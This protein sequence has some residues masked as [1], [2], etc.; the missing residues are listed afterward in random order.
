MLALAFAAL[1]VASFL[2]VAGLRDV[3]VATGRTQR[4]R[5]LVVDDSLDARAS[6][7]FVWNRRFVRTRPGRWV[8]RQLVLA[9]VERPPLLVA[10]VVA[11]AAVASGWALF[12]VL[13]PVFALLG[14][15][16]G[17]QGLRVFLA[18]AR[19]RRLEA[20]INQMPELARV[21]ANATSAGL[22][23]RTA[24]DMAADELADPASTELRIVAD[25]MRVGADLETAMAQINE[26]L[27]S[28]EIRVLIS[29]LLV[30][31]RSGGSLVTSLRDIAD[32]L[33]MRKEVRREVRTVLAQA[34]L[35]GYLVV[36]LGL[37]L[38]AGLNLFHSGTVQRMTTEP[39]GQAALLTSGVLYAIGL[40][41]IRRITRIEP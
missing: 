16:I 31:S 40:L 10:I 41:M 37:M 18:R 27:P 38:T 28:R 20:F 39:L 25:Q 19:D 8:Q 9:G 2:A 26:R 21:L 34:V 15:V 36:G 30:S 11:A 4:L 5:L 22:S 7:M 17:L 14:A 23:I 32:T 12:V 29:T 3:L 6:A 35:T 24:I 13:A 1:L 33:E